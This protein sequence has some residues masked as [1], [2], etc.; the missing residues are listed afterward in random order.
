MSDIG[1]VSLEKLVLKSEVSMNQF[2]FILYVS[3]V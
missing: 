3:S 1:K 2:V